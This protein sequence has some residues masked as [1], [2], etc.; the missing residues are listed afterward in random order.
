MHIVHQLGR[1]GK[2]VFIDALEH[3]GFVRVGN[4][5]VGLVDMAVAE[6]LAG[7]GGSFDPELHGNVLWLHGMSPH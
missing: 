5:L 4:D 6:A 3:I 2:Y 7:N 1:V